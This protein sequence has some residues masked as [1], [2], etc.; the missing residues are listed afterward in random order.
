MLRQFNKG[1]KVVLLLGDFIVIIV[2]FQ[3][4]FL[5][6]IGVSVPAGSRLLALSITAFMYLIALFIFDLYD[7][8]YRVRS[9]AYLSKYIYAVVTGT[10][11]IAMVYYLFPQLKFGRSIY[12][13]NLFLVSI[14][15]YLWRLLFDSLGSYSKRMINVVI[16]GSG[17]AGKTIYEIL[18]EKTSFFNIIGFLDDNPALHGKRIDSK[19]VIG[20]SSTI[21]S[22]AEKKQIDAAVVAI[23]HT[24][25]LDLLKSIIDAKMRGVE[26][27]D[28]PSLYEELTGKLPVIHMGYDWIA[29]TTFKGVKRT[30][31]MM[32]A[33]RLVDIL[34][35]IAGLL[36]SFPMAILI[37]LAIKIDSRGSVLYRQRRVGNNEQMFDLIKFRSMALDAESKGAV[38][39]MANDPRVTRVGGFLRKTRMDE[40]PQMWNVLKGDMS[41][42]GPRPERPEFVEELKRS[43]P[44]YSFRHYV[45]PGITGWAQINYQ[46]GASKEDALEKL[47][48]DLY[49]IKNQSPLLD[50]NI[51][52]RT[53]SVVLLGKGAR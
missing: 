8:K 52:F 13:I 46:Y 49:Y 30:I 5:I 20:A 39:A 50:V 40:I 36:I 24:K 16:I 44:Y 35:S 51:L 25:H 53:I 6:R 4:A 34:L 14:N 11:S 41:F 29:R 31:Y 45:K 21:S 37:Y 42:I 28:M 22:L 48:Y 32:H 43:I 9:V 7:I 19:L 10:I 47:Q 38:W 1:K 23:T 33:K 18:K 15:V 17:Q 2:S 27:F 26:I 3:L 12:L